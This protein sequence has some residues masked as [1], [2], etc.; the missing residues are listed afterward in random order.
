MS[1]QRLA[2]SIFN[3][4]KFVRSLCFQYTQNTQSYALMKACFHPGCW[5]AFL[6]AADLWSGRYSIILVWSP[7]YINPSSFLISYCWD[8]SFV[9][10]T[11]Q[12]G[13]YFSYLFSLIFCLFILLSRRQ[14]QCS[15]GSSVITFSLYESFCVSWLYKVSSV[16]LRMFEVLLFL[17]SNRILLCRPS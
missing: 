2:L 11:L 7:F 14:S 9:V 16:S 8:F 3:L 10:W 12:T 4:W 5:R 17:F 1:H 13:L 6:H 15:I